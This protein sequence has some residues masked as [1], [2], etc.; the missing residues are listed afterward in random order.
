VQANVRALGNALFGIA[1]RELT[2][3]WGW[4]LLALVATGLLCLAVL[5]SRVR[6]VEIVR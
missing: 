1:D 4:P 3:P 6:A 2:L 5:R